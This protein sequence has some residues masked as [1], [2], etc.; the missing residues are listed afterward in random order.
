MCNRYATLETVEL[1]KE[2]TITH[3]QSRIIG[4]DFLV[5]GHDHTLGNLLQT[6]LV[7]NLFDT[8]QITYAGYSIPHPLRDEMLLR[9]GVKNGLES[10]AKKAFQDAARGCGELFKNL[11]L[12]WKAAMSG[13]L[14][15]TVT[16][17]KTQPRVR[18]RPRVAA[19]SK[20]P[21]SASKPP[22]PNAVPN[23]SIIP[24]EFEEKKE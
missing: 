3:A 8:E 11:K 23:A 19:S 16:K 14:V 15:N 10:T 24:N 9:I 7:E 6:Y 4:F 1:P 5:R 18:A 21:V 20:L 12:A 2:I 22:I 17:E 13:N